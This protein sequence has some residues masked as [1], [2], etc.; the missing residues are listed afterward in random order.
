MQE[1]D[2]LTEDYSRRPV[3]DSAAVT[4][5]KIAIVLVGAI[6]TL[7]VFLVGAELG[8]ALGLKQALLVF[9]ITGMVLAVIA[10]ACGVLAA[11]TRLTT[12]V[13]IQYSFGRTGAKV[14]SAFIG[15]TILGWYGATV[16]MFAR[17]VQIIVRDMGVEPLSHR[18]YLVVASVLMIVTAIFGFKGLDRLS[19]LAVP[20][21]ICLLVS[22]VYTAATSFELPADV[23]GAMGLAEGISVGIGG[24]I[25]GVTMFPDV[26]RYARSSNDAILAALLSFGLGVPV[27][28]LLAAIPVV[29]TAEAN[30]LK[31]I[32]IVGLGVTGLALLL[33]AT[34]TTNA[35]N[36]YST[37]LVLATIVEKVAKWKLVIVVGVVGTMIALMPIL[38]NFLYFLHFLAVMIP[39]VA[40]VYLA[41]YF[42][43]HRQ[44]YNNAVLKSI[45][46]Y[47]PIAF[48]A[49]ILGSLVGYFA[50]EDIILIT[51]VP[52]LDAIAIG[53]FSYVFLSYLTAK[54]KLLFDEV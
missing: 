8:N 26:C 9:S 18:F 7:P 11:R 19:K 45:S 49:W 30:F 47:N 53:F 12:W 17:A 41:D 39:P 3:P 22:L 21:M 6:I 42:W 51:T 31:V 24:F 44:S 37:S 36:L 38:D 54:K 23:K 52:A 5:F 10:A 27:I 46:A 33:L 4:G 16:D 20:I 25:V 43:L 28:L 32:L 29:A 14:V 1:L 15:I 48:I 50:G 40:G 34:W 35:Y 2:Q 13:I